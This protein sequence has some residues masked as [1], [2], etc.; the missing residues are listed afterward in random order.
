MGGLSQD[1]S[2]G[3]NL[4]AIGEYATYYGFDIGRQEERLFALNVLGLASSPSDA[5]KAVV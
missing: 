2:S 1:E 5:A 4:R 3:L